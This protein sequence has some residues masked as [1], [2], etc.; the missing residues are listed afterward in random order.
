MSQ[1]AANGAEDNRS[2]RFRQG[3]YMRMLQGIG[4]MSAAGTGP[5]GNA[6]VRGLSSNSIIALGGSIRPGLVLGGALLASDATA[7]FKGGP[8]VDA[9]VTTQGQPPVK[10]TSK[11]TVGT[12]GIGLLLDWYPAPTGGWHTGLTA[13][14][15]FTSLQN[16][17]D[18][19][20]MVGT[21]A[22]GGLFGGYDWSIGKDWSLGLSLLVMGNT[23]AN[24][25][26]SK[27]ASATGYRLQSFSAGLGASVLYF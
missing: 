21:S 22:V 9:T 15:G 23:S 14:I 24:M 25:K 7:K 1:P 2:D 18:E 4:F 8:F 10:A 26:D 13:G 16:L 19:S 6:S 3:F 11:A 27:D 5:Y 20:V 17:A 12:S